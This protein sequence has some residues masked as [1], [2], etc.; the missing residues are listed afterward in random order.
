[1]KNKRKKLK[2]VSPKYKNFITK[3]LP[4]NNAFSL[5]NSN[6]YS[7]GDKKLAKCNYNT[8]LDNL[9][10]NLFASSLNTS[11]NDAIIKFITLVGIYNV[12]MLQPVAAIAGDI[13]DRS[14]NESSIP[15]VE[16]KKFD[17]APTIGEKINSAIQTVIELIQEKFNCIFL[18]KTNSDCKNLRLT[19]LFCILF[20]LLVFGM[21]YGFSTAVNTYYIFKKYMY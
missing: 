5:N 8:T 21:F 17:S 20:C 9:P 1:M 15:G 12:L 7:G 2:Q 3:S 16:N 13:V 4:K 6:I 14:S 19:I 11:Y 18:D 10:P